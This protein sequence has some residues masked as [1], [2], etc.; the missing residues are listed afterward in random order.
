[1]F[2]D[3]TADKFEHL[4]GEAFQNSHFVDSTVAVRGLEPTTE[5]WEKLSLPGMSILEI[6]PGGGHL[7]AAAQ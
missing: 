2:R 7:L 5:L 4:H 6:G 1:V 3:I